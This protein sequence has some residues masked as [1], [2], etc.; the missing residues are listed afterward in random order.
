MQSALAGQESLITKSLLDCLE[1]DP[2]IY[3]RMQ[4]FGTLF[5]EI[6]F[7]CMIMCHNIVELVCFI[8]FKLNDLIVKSN[9]PPPV[10]SPHNLQV[11]FALG[12]LPADCITPLVVSRLL[13]KAQGDGPV[14]R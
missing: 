6:S 4:V 13:A 10:S 12:Q 8:L 3:V 2:S 7:T 11:A 9:L 14:A 5:T 1:L